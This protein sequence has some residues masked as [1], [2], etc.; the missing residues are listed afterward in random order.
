ML[1]TKHGHERTARD[2]LTIRWISCISCISCISYNSSR[3]AR[4][5]ESDRIV[6]WLV[7]AHAV[8]AVR[9]LLSAAR[10]ALVVHMIKETTSYHLILRVLQGLLS[11]QIAT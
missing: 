9:L 1:E 5:I 11:G 10:Q 3:S 4:P 7:L 8:A 2:T 6:T